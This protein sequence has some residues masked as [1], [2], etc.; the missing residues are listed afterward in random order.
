MKKIRVFLASLLT[1][2]WVGSGLAAPVFAGVAPKPAGSVKGVENYAVSVKQAQAM[3]VSAQNWVKQMAAL[4]ATVALVNTP[5]PAPNPCDGWTPPP[6]P[7]S[8]PGPRW[9]QPGREIYNPPGTTVPWGNSTG[10]P[11]APKPAAA[12]GGGGR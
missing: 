1:I 6:V 11:Y 8:P 7:S 2:V 12:A 3:A 10:D 9:N 4:M 5:P